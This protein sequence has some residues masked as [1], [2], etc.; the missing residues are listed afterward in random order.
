[1]ET[2]ETPKCP[3]CVETVAKMEACIR[4]HPTESALVSL[5]AGFLIAQLPLRLLAGGIARLTL[6]ALK[7]AALLYCFYRVAE[8][9]YAR[10]HPAAAKPD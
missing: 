1:M 8:D 3:R 9:C 5:G 6:V 2:T 7:P 4:Q 10:R